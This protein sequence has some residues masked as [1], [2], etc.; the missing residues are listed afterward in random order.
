MV[1]ALCAFRV[2]SN[3]LLDSRLWPPLGLE[4]RVNKVRGPGTL[5]PRALP[6]FALPPEAKALKEML[7]ANIVYISL[8]KNSMQRELLER[9]SNHRSNGLG[10]ESL[11][12]M[13]GSEREPKL[14]LASV[15]LAGAK[16]HVPNESARRLETHSELKPS[17]R[18][19]RRD[20]MQARDEQPRFAEWIWALPTL[21]A[22]Y[23]CITAVCGKGLGIAGSEAPD[24]E[25][26]GHEMLE[27]RIFHNYRMGFFVPY[28]LVP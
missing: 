24:D 26:P 20:V 19:P 17:A 4:L 5:E 18:R 1:P 21:I 10:S 9:V 13:D 12:L 15:S 27:R 7:R 11:P 25:A 16:S 22:R 8:G 14:G 6:Q 2:C 28:S 23:L 3:R